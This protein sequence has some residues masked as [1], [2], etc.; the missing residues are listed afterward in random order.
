MTTSLLHLRTG[1]ARYLFGFFLLTSTTLIAQTPTK[2][3]DKS[4]GGSHGDD[5][6]VLLKL[7]DGGYLVGGYSLSSPHEPGEKSA[8]HMGGGDFWVIR[9]RAD[10][11]KLW[12][13]TYG[14][15]LRDYLM[16][17]V[18]APDGGFL[19]GGESNSDPLE[20]KKQAPAYGF[21]DF[22]V[23]KIDGDGNYQWDQSY[24]GSKRDILTAMVVTPQ[25]DGYLLGGNTGE[26]YRVIRIDL[27]GK[28]QWEKTYGGSGTDY[29]SA[30]APTPD[31]NVLLAGHSNSPQSE[32][33]EAEHYGGG[34]Y[35]LVKID[36]DGTKLWDKALG[37]T[38]SDN[39]NA[40]IATSDGG[41]LLG[42]S[43]FSNSSS[44]KSEPP[45]G[46]FDFWIVKLDG[47]GNRVWDRTLGGGG[48]DECRTLLETPEGGYLIAGSSASD[49]SPT[50]SE[51]SRG[52]SDYWLVKLAADGQVQWD[53]TL[54]SNSDESVSA[55]LQ[56]QSDEFLLLG[57]SESYSGGDK[58][59]EFWGASDAWLVA[60]KVPSCT[61]PT[62]T[63]T[64]NVTTLPIL[65]NT[66]GVSL[67]ITGCES[68]TIRW[69]GPNGVSGTTPL[70]PV[71][72]TAIGSLVYSATCTV[73]SC[74]G[75]ASTTLTVAAPWVNASLDGYIYG[76]DCASFRGWA[77]DRN[78]PNA[79][80]SIDIL[81]G[82]N[83]I[84][85]L[86]ADGF[87]QD[88]QTAGKGNGKHAFSFTIPP[89]L[90]DNV[91]HTLYARV[92][93]SSFLLKDSPKAIVCQSSGSPGNRAPVPPASSVINT[94]LAAQVG[95]PFSTTLAAFTDPDGDALTYHLSGLPDGLSI[96]AGTRVLSG[97]PTQAG[98]FLLA[99]A[100]TDT[101]NATNSVS[102]PLTV[103]PA[104][105]TTVTGSFEGYLDK[106]ECGTIRGW[107]WDRNKPNSPVTVEFYS[108]TEGGLETVWGS[109]VANI[110]RDDLKK[111]G[112]GNGSHGYSFAVPN[113]LKDGRRRVMY[114]RVQGSSYTLKDSGK[115]LT[116]GSPAR[117][118]A[119]ADSELQVR[120]LG[121]PVSDQLTVEIRG[122]ENQSVR[123]QLTD[124]SGRLINQRQIE[125]AKPVEQQTFIVRE[126]PAGLLLLRVSSGLKSL[127]LKV[128][129]Q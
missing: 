102:F 104:Q 3:W 126:Q 63:M 81:E 71:S 98:T 13:K 113:G 80:V 123:L 9:Y 107:V 118:S 114:G 115:P 111:A 112:K 61:N 92:S 20:G 68:G 72:T 18:A 69:A 88:L 127:T 101:K 57:Y 103:H 77:W 64:S 90:K 35:W 28:L 122:M 12:D 124:A 89:A 55:V 7:P 97:T 106:V 59:A 73:G 58:E 40:L 93:G 27:K 31:G 24:G 25:Q 121:N 51:N 1:L 54:G 76:A 110:Y 50:K 26:D 65:Q 49:Q 8:E 41:F 52:E 21:G 10:H 4:L 100:A 129:K 36:L 43:S 108:K 60:V 17:I 23:V 56:R 94:P 79:A 84:A 30:M 19:L 14:G 33:K 38:S 47:Q 78:K 2:L 67:A 32:D 48:Y 66:P 120:V 125:G 83:V 105:T 44:T 75:S 6:R 22:W 74:T 53:K 82:P 42:G 45:L 16:N 116:C 62:I 5:G 91:P 87:R 34:D 37:G 70:I 15:L 119:E 85:T 96:Q 29:L 39:C 109:T 86:S 128:L 11:T 117:L 46:H 99:Y 95:V